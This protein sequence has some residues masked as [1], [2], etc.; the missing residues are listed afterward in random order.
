MLILTAIPGAL[1]RLQAEVDGIDPDPGADADG[2][3]VQ[4]GRYSCLIP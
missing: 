2:F 1:L 4:W 3:I